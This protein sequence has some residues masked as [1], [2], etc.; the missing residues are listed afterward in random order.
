MTKIWLT[1]IHFHQKTKSKSKPGVNIKT[2]LTLSISLKKHVL[3]CLTMAVWFL[4]ALYCTFTGL[5]TNC[6]HDI[7]YLG[8]YVHINRLTADSTKHSK[9]LLAFSITAFG[10]QQQPSQSL[11]ACLASTSLSSLEPFQPT[12]LNKHQVG[13][14][15]SFYREEKPN[16]KYPDIPRPLP[17]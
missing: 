16:L 7:M 3:R 1:N 10:E 4:K 15:L 9:R 8:F 2:G 5:C 14:Y 12:E 11:V 13:L 17:I 6:S